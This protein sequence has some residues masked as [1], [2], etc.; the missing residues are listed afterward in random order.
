MSTVGKSW[1]LPLYGKYCIRGKLGKMSSISDGFTWCR[2]RWFYQSACC[3]GDE[4]TNSYYNP[5]NI[6]MLSE[7]L[8]RQ[9]FRKDRSPNSGENQQKLVE[10][11]RNVLKQHD[12]WGKE[13]NT[14]PEVDIKLPKLHGE[15]I[16]DH[17][18]HLASN[19]TAEYRDLGDALS[20]TDLPSLPKTWKF[21]K[22]WTRYGKDGSSVLVDF[23]EENAVVFDIE[24]LM[25]E[26]NFPTMA[27]AASAE[28]W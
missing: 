24:C 25:T 26:G 1:K 7:G 23:P 22:G 27:T 15:N 3:Y 8:Y 20:A 18:R 17:F 14:L 12:L 28:A 19:Q 10:K 5:L 9:I 6:Q 11:S 21:Q 16:D 2:R 13:T 4:G